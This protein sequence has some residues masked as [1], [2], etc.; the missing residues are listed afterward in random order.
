MI[1]NAAPCSCIVGGS[2]CHLLTFGCIY[3]YFFTEFHSVRSGAFSQAWRPAVIRSASAPVALW[4]CELLRNAIH[5]W[6]TLFISISRFEIDK[7]NN[8]EPWLSIFGQRR[9]DPAERSPLLGNGSPILPNHRTRKY[10]CS[11]L[12]MLITSVSMFTVVAPYL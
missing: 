9:A 8:S 12:A 2:L 10:A 3:E 1:R 7:F 6:P 11:T 5:F 4:G